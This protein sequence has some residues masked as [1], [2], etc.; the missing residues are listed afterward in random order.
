MTKAR[1]ATLEVL[2]KA[3]K[4]LSANEISEK[5]T[6]S[7]DPATVYRTLHYLE[8]KGFTESFVLHCT[9]HGTER[10]YTVKEGSAHHHWFHCK[11]CHTF[12]DLGDCS[13]SHLIDGYEKHMGIEVTGHTLYLTGLC[14]DCA[15]K[16]TSTL[17]Q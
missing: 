4:P 11:Q 13:L 15:Q 8:N 7:C 10:Y 14:H 6:L 3:D 12:I 5:M 16:K 9:E 2:Q 1:Q 17:K